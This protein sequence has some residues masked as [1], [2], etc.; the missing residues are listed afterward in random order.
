MLGMNP[1]TLNV[2]FSWYPYGSNGGTSSEV[3][4]IRN[5]WARTYQKVKSDKRIGAVFSNDLSDTPITM[6]RNAAVLEARKAGADVLVMCD[7][8][9]HPDLL[10]GEDPSAK[11]FWDSSFDFLYERKTQGK[12]TCVGAPYCGPPPIEN[13]YCFRWE[14]WETNGAEL[15]ARIEAYSRHEAARMAGI[16]P[17]AALPTGLIMFDMKLF[18]VTDPIHE[19][20]R[21]CQIYPRDVAE[22]LT[23][24]W[25]YYEWEDIYAAKKGSTEDVT[26]TRDMGLL[27]Q[28]KL[29]YDVLF[30][31]WD[32]WAG[33]YKPK[34]VGKPAVVTSDM[35]NDK[36]K[37]AVLEGRH[38]QEQIV[39]VTKD[40]KWLD[41]MRNNPTIKA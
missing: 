1:A 6:T 14:N 5:W 29:G 24:S 8:D 4:A 23:H 26:C 16:H 34:C 30:C 41:R 17:A 27:A 13:C 2:F 18:E 20:K 31:N 12:V 33:H 32:A 3:P 25:F 22:K 35:V 28:M 37:T 19:F 7:S 40:G 21:L 11:P 10:V 38:S 36:Y 9:Q 15:G 39:E